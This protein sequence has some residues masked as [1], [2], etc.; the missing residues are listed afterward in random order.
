MSPATSSSA[1]R[2]ANPARL[3]REPGGFACRVVRKPR[4]R[5]GRRVEPV[6]PPA[7]FPG[8]REGGP[9]PGTPSAR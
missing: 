5:S 8:G 4:S 9:A 3:L 2:T 1:Y 6:N 7:G